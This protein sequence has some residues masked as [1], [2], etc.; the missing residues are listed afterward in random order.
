MCIQYLTG[1]KYIDWVYFTA[2]LNNSDLFPQ[3]NFWK[4]H[5]AKYYQSFLKFDSNT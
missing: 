4:L 2:I 5:L 3:I 1:A